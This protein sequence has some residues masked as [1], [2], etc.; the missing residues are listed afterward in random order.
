[1]VATARQSA[2][3]IGATNVEFIEGT[4]EALPL[5][6]AWADVVIS[7]GV[8]NLAPD[9]RAVIREIHRVLKPNGRLQIGA[10]IVQK[11]VPESARRNIDLWAG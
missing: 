6:E 11:A 1:M 3:E 9:K 10:I 4:I 2:S 5:P 7:N 8:V